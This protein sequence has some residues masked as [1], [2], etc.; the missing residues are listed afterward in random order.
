MLPGFKYYDYDSDTILPETLEI[1]NKNSK[2]LNDYCKIVADILYELTALKNSAEAKAKYENENMDAYPTTTAGIW[3][4]M[5]YISLRLNL[6]Y[7]VALQ[8]QIPEI[9]TIKIGRYVSMRKNNAKYQLFNSMKPV[10]NGAEKQTN[11]YNNVKNR[12]SILTSALKTAEERAKQIYA[13]DQCVQFYKT[14]I[15]NKITSNDE[16]EAKFKS[17]FDNLTTEEI[18]YLTKT[19]FVTKCYF[20]TEERNSM[21]LFKY[22]AHRLIRGEE[23]YSCCFNF[24]NNYC[25]KCYEVRRFDP[26]FANS[27]NFIYDDEFY[28]GAGFY[29]LQYWVMSVFNRKTSLDHSDLKKYIYICTE[30]DLANSWDSGEID[31]IVQQDDPSFDDDVEGTEL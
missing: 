18:G 8:L 21:G 14:H 29:E 15:E 22:E 13:F 24:L 12:I 11:L 16:L 10:L 6:C 19:T 17:I 30:C 26:K 4:V 25:V 20:N 3:K 27:S 2:K 23:Y 31:E 5:N 9:Q 1:L 7:K 28:E